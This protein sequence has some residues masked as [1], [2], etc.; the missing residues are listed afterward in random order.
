LQAARSVGPRLAGRGL[1]EREREQVYV[2]DQDETTIG[3]LLFVDQELAAL[4]PRRCWA[5]CRKVTPG[6]RSWSSLG[7]W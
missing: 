3:Q 1:R 7:L 2:H 5:A 6:S 4:M